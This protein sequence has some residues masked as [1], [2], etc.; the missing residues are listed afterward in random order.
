[1]RAHAR[2]GF[3]DRDALETRRRTPAHHEMLLLRA[4]P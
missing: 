3:G 1:V 4:D 2:L